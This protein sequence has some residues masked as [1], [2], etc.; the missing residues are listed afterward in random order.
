M[1]HAD[2]KN[3]NNLDIGICIDGG[4]NV[5][6]W[7]VFFAPFSIKVHIFYLAYNL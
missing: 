4:L 1:H 5:R 3:K 7:Y 2:N 6:F